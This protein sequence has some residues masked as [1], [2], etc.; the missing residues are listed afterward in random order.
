MIIFC[1]S[2]RKKFELNEN[3]IPDKGRL[4]KCGSCDQTWFYNKKI[5]SYVKPSIK[6][7]YSSRFKED[8]NTENNINTNNE[9]VNQMDK[10]FVDKIKPQKDMILYRSDKNSLTINKIFSYLVVVSISLVALFIVLETFKNPL[11]NAFP[12]EGE[13]GWYLWN[14]ITLVKDILIFTRDLIY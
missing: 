11:Y 13:F 14:L 9:N 12:N 2:C 10:N 4:L 8:K 3:L 5:E 1:P 7:E 6:E